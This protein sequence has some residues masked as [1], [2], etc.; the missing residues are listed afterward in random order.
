[1]LR[2]PSKDRD[3]IQINGAKETFDALRKLIRE[4]SES[5]D[6]IVPSGKS[7]EENAELLDLIALVSQG[8]KNGPKIRLLVPSSFDEALLGTPQFSKISW[9]KVDLDSEEGIWVFDKR[10]ALIY[11]SEQKTANLVRDSATMSMFISILNALWKEAELRE[12]GD[13]ARRELIDTLSREEKAKRQ[14]QLLQ[15][16]LTHDIRNYNQV[17]RLSAELLKEE[18]HEDSGV[19]L[20]LDSII[21]AIDGSTEFL[22]RAKRLGRAISEQAPRLY[23][24]SLFHVIDKSLTLIRTAYS[25]KEIKFTVEMGESDTPIPIH[26]IIGKKLPALDYLSCNVVADDLLVEVFSNILSNSVKYTDEDTVNIDCRIDKIDEQPD[27]LEKEMWRITVA[28]RGHG[29]PDKD[30]PDIF[31]RYLRGARGIGLGMSIIH[32]LV[33]DRYGG[34]VSVRNRVKGDHSQGAVIEMFLRS[35]P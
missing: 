33:V 3:K 27:T 17:T 31:S 14:A 32:A 26:E 29:I 18:L 7:Q 24:V 19:Q 5:I 6:L 2:Q 4:S 11:E 35:S 16:I 28:D 8:E 9:R 20:I 12:T 21:R 30:K 15:D 22:E 34:S 13:M 25:K 10:V 23:P 1:M